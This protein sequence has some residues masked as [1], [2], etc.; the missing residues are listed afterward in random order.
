MGT[1]GFIAGLFRLMNIFA[2]TIG[3]IFGDKAGIR[4]GLRGRVIF[5]GAVLLLEGI[6]LMG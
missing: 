3:G 5:L 1:A 4:F 2:R 6:A